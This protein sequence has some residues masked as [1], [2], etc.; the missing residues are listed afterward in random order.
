MTKK[1]ISEV[2][3]SDVDFDHYTIPEIFERLGKYN[4]PEYRV[5]CESVFR[6]E[7]ESVSGE[8]ILNIVHRRLQTDEEYEIEQKQNRDNLKQKKSSYLK[9]K[10]E[11]LEAGVDIEE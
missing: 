9:L 8:L 7:C 4:T 10:K 5:E 2:V 3:W 6:V 11:L 1:I